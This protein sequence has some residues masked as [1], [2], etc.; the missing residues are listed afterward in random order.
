MCSL[1][2]PSVANA[3]TIRRSVRAGS[4]C[5]IVRWRVNR[6]TKCDGSNH[7]MARRA[8]AGR[9]SIRANQC[10]I[11]WLRMGREVGRLGMIRYQK[12]SVTNATTYKPLRA[13]QSWLAVSIIEGGTCAVHVREAKLWLSS[14]PTCTR[15][16]LCTWVAS[17]LWGSHFRDILQQAHVFDAL[18]S[19]LSPA[20]GCR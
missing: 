4:G 14:S 10:T 8:M 12:P 3:A 5:E 6:R 9:I 18:Q 19:A 15:L 1:A 16:V 11:V 13:A 20:A 7:L 2:W 17:R